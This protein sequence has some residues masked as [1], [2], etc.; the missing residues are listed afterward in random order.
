MARI[1][2]TEHLDIYSS[3]KELEKNFGLIYGKKTYV[4]DFIGGKATFKITFNG[5]WGEDIYA[6]RTNCYATFSF[7]KGWTRKKMLETGL[8]EL[9]FLT[10]KS[11][12][13]WL[14]IE[15]VK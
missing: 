13:D 2:K 7:P 10:S 14:T 1:Y 4:E 9:G 6:P 11:N 12:L 5:K 8:N 15:G 3:N